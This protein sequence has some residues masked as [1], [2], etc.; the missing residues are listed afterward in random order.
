MS[1]IA[2]AWDAFMQAI[3]GARALT[4]SGAEQHE[5][6]EPVRYARELLDI[7]EAEITPMTFTRR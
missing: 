3:D 4:V 1:T 6:A 2:Q 7:I 5:I